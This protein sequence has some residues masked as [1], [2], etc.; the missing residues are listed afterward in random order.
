AKSLLFA[1]RGPRRRSATARGEG[2]GVRR[3]RHQAQ[4][5]QRS[6]RRAGK[7]GPRPAG[8][9]FTGFPGDSQNPFYSQNGGRS[10]RPAVLRIVGIKG[11]GRPPALPRPAA[12]P[13]QVGAAA[14]GRGA[15]GSGGA[16]P[17]SAR[18]KR[19]PPRQALGDG[20]LLEQP[21][22]VLL[23]AAAAHPN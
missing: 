9:G 19:S 12:P 11:G 1:E 20:H 8:S 21:P 10:R 14:G 16:S 18:L 17:R 22:E 5:R 23:T 13:R 7:A 6:R 2:H 15:F 3:L 4:A